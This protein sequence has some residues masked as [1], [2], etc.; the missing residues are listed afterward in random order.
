MKPYLTQI[1]KNTNTF[2]FEFM[3][4]AVS[5]VVMNDLI[6]LFEKNS[7]ENDKIFVNSIIPEE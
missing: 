7:Y 3:E 5:R 1:L 6:K 4:T 2:I